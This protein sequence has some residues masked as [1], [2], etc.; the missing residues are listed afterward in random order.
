[1]G[2]IENSLSVRLTGIFLKYGCLLFILYL[3]FGYFAAPSII[4][5]QMRQQLEQTGRKMHVEHIRYNPLA[6]SLDMHGLVIDDPQGRPQ[7][8]F[9]RLYGN[10]EASSLLWST[11]VFKELRLDNFTYHYTIAKDGSSNIDDLL[12]LANT[13]DSEP[14]ADTEEPQPVP[15]ILIKQ[16][17]LNGINLTYRDNHRPKPFYKA[18]GPIYISLY[19]FNTF[20]GNGYPYSVE[21]N[22]EQG[23]KISWQGDLSVVPLRSQGDIEI[24]GIRLRDGWAFAEEMLNF[25]LVDGRLAAHGHYQLSPDGNV[26]LSDANIKLDKIDIID[27]K[28]AQPALNIPSFTLSGINL[29]LQQQ[30]VEIGRI[31]SQKAVF[32]EH[33]DADGQSRL[34]Q[35][36]T[37]ISSGN[38]TDNQADEAASPWQ[39]Q[40]N[41]FAL[42]DYRI[43]LDTDVVGKPL[44]FTL[45]K[46]NLGFEQFNL[47]DSRLKNL[48]LDTT[49][50]GEGS[51]ASSQLSINSPQ[52]A[53]AP[54]KT[55]VNVDLKAFPLSHAQPILDDLANLQLV[56]GTL[57]SKLN[58]QLEEGKQL[59]IVAKG[60]ASIDTLNL[61]DTLKQLPFL[62]WDSL[63]VHD[64]AY[65][66]A[67]NSL[68][69]DSIDTDALFARVT[70]H[71]D[72]TSNIQDILAHPSQ[73]APAQPAQPAD[74]EQ[75]GNTTPMSINV[76]SINFNNARSR[77]SDLSL[78]RRFAMTIGEINGSIKDISSATDGR[79]SVDLKGSVNRY[80]PVL[81]KGQVNP[82]A[83]ETY[84]DLAL[85]FHGLELT[86]LT[87]Y[88]D[89]YAGY[90]IDK[91]KL[92]VELNYK[93][94]N[95][96]IVGGNHLFI[97]QLTLGDHTN[98]STATSLP[99]ALAIALLKDS[100]GQI[101]IKLEVEGSLDDPEFNYG[102]LLWDAATSFIGKII[103]SPFNL[104]ASLVESSEPLNEINFAFGSSELDTTS[105]QTLSDLADA[106]KQRPQLD[107]E[108]RSNA[109]SI[110]DREALARTKLGQQLSI[111]MNTISNSDWNKLNDYYQQSN[112]EPSLNELRQEI[113]AAQPELS[114]QQVETQL[115]SHVLQTLLLQ[116]NIS[117]HALKQLALKRSNNIRLA[118][119]AQAIGHDRVFVLD[120]SLVDTP[121]KQSTSALEL[122]AH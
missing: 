10:F 45:S 27:K 84:T 67:A 90:A 85:S 21:A 48:Q 100:R 46:L 104:L 112:S 78:S 97:D 26:K 55:S 108:I 25:E 12:A 31:D 61:V 91:G 77:F 70:L 9:D 94:L 34:Q 42:K 103:A 56:D 87:P 88:A 114:K 23:E 58:L 15:R 63:D 89:V 30:R 68:D 41:K 110:A 69:I 19:Y 93:M 16:L 116:Q 74:K 36:L 6:L 35:L 3:L 71:K 54:L 5:S 121:S 98:S 47:G 86:N 39:V 82:L 2:L 92:T 52:L 107:L 79:A 4:E 24:S 117:D 8:S 96:R 101:D 17:S 83:A 66:S 122:N 120:S 51:E 81:L 40:L 115:Q 118:L 95:N 105:T 44:N 59:S 50:D 13:P 60:E 1:M 109:N 72:G 57:S 28:T 113:V 99:V 29:D 33:I 53:Y 18:F 119:I 37:P 22:T 102:S 76:G 80:A 38:N 62:S 20:P 65:S 75:Q 111:D 73:S 64:I 43:D 14:E 7:L 106:L 32:H 49:I 11:V